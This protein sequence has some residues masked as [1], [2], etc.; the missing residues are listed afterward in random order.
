MQGHDERSLL[1]LERLLKDEF[2]LKSLY[3]EKFTKYWV[4][5][6]NRKI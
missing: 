3:F 6:N 2:M 1:E 5:H 4:S